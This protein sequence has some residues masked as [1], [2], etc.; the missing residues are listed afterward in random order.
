MSTSVQIDPATG[1]R[2][3][4]PVKGIGPFFTP[5][6]QELAPAAPPVDIDPATGERRVHKIDLNAPSPL[7]ARA[8][9]QAGQPAAP[10]AL[11]AYTQPAPDTNPHLDTAFLNGAGQGALEGA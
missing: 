2:L 5:G 6:P 7:S 3:T 1:E 10:A 4:A 8:P 11:P 9:L